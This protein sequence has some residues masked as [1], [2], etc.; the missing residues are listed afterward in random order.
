MLLSFNR[1]KY[2]LLC[3]TEYNRFPWNGRIMVELLHWFERN[4]KLNSPTILQKRIKDYMRPYLVN[5]VNKCEN[6]RE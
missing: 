3:L 1:I 5:M 6:Y 2:K 4:I